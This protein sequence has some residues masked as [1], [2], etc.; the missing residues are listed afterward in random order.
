MGHKWWEGQVHQWVGGSG[1]SISGPPS[2]WWEGQVHQWVPHQ[3]WEGQVHPPPVVG[4]ADP[5]PTSSGRGRLTLSVQLCR[6]SM[7]E[8]RREHELEEQRLR[9]LHQQEVTALKAAHS[10]TQ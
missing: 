8:V 1:R 7:E 9:S 10:H 3:W 2:P 4:G 5:P 6:S